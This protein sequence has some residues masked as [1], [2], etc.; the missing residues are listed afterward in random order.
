MTIEI[1]VTRLRT[2]VDELWGAVN[3]LALIALEDQPQSPALA[4]AD[5]LAESVSELQ[6]EV[7][8][9]RELLS[10]TVSVAQHELPAVFPDVYVHLA[11]FDRRLE[12]EVRGHEAVERVAAAAERARR[13]WP[14]WHRSVLE[15]ADRLDAPREDVTSAIA[16]CLREVCARPRATQSTPRGRRMDRPHPIEEAN[17]PRRTP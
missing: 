8:G 4:A 11:R 13:D 5:H 14:A 15:S 2:A 1:T 10:E 6:G 16:D 9:A 17:H 7:A 3:E 12:R